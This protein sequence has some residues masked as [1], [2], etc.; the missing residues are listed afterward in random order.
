VLNVYLL[1]RGYW[2]TLTDIFAMATEAAGVVLAFA[3][4]TGPSLI[5]V[6]Q[7]KLS[8]ILGESSGVVLSLFSIVPLIV[9][10]ILV[11]V[12]SIEVIQILRRML[13]RRS[14]I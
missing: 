2:Q 6:E 7:D 10:V 4:L 1:R 11:V 8:E 3:M 12:Q 5:S 9:L 13:R 14:Q